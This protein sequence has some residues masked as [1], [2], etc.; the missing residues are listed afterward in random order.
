MNFMQKMKSYFND[1]KLSFLDYNRFIFDILLMIILCTVITLTLSPVITDIL[2]V[3]D[4]LLLVV[5]LFSIN[6]KKHLKQEPLLWIMTITIYLRFIFNV[7]SIILITVKSDIGFISNYLAYFVK[8]NHCIFGFV[9][10]A[11]IS[12]TSFIIIPRNSK[13]ILSLFWKF[14]DDKMPGKTLS[15]DADLNAGRIDEEEAKEKRKILDRE[16]NLHYGMMHQVVA[17]TTL[18]TIINLFICVVC[19]TC[20]IVLVTLKSS[21]SVVLSRYLYLIITVNIIYQFL[22]LIFSILYRFICENSKKYID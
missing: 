19:I 13:Y 14:F 1:N 20:G 12:I 3:I 2:L 15:I 22:A 18:D 11:I 16:I 8:Y 5:L 21:I 6:Y 17:D 9:T 4:V 10:F 7:S